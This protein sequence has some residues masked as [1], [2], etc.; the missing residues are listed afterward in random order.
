[1]ISAL[2]AY[3]G[4]AYMPMVA[5]EVRQAHRNVHRAL[6]LGMAVI[7]ALYGLANLAYFWVLPFAEVATA[8]STNYRDALP[9]AAKAAQVFLG[10]RGPAIASLLFMISAAGALNGVII[11]TARIPYAMAHDGLFFSRVGRLSGARVPALAIVLLVV[12]SALLAVSGTF[13]QLTDMTVFGLWI[14]YGLT[15]TTVFALR[16]KM[17]DAPRPYRAFGYPI[18]PAIFVLVSIWLLINTLTT[19][20]VEAVASLV[21]IGLGFPLYAYFRRTKAK[22]H[23]TGR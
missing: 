4:W 6:I 23:T 7:L 11:T 9:V 20:T 12:W 10:S 22:G 16:R 13:D 15:A 17:P 5:G 14:F 21:L 1:M 18:V 19:S 3:D 2:W 8:N